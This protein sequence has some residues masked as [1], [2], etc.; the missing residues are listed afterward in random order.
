MKIA[1]ITSSYPQG[2][3]FRGGLE[4]LCTEIAVGMAARGHKIT[5]LTTSQ[6]P[7]AK[8]S[9][10]GGITVIRFR[11]IESFFSRLSLNLGLSLHR[12]KSEFDVILNMEY[13]NGFLSLE[14]A[15]LCSPKITVLFPL[16]HAMRGQDRARTLLHRGYRIIGALILE[17]SVGIVCLSRYEAESL[18]SVFPGQ[19]H[20]VTIIRP[21]VQA[22]PRAAKPRFA[23][24]ILVIS[25]LVPFKGVLSVIKAL[26]LLPNHFLDVVGDGPQRVELEKLATDMG[27]RPRIKF[28]GYV[29][30]AEKNELLGSASVLVHLS[31]VESYSL[32]VGEALASGLPCVVRNANAL[33]EW[34]DSRSCI[35]VEDPENS[36]SLALSIVRAESLVVAKRIPTTEEYAAI[37][38]RYLDRIVRQ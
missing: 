16:F 4:K 20:K 36:Q 12:H 2:T 14:A 22:A 7:S 32:V 29:S 11:W 35:G 27:I 37:L 38:E 3:V 13:W 30:D 25:S 15:V 24:K 9:C 23:F 1:I 21:G 10:A 26:T 19:R 8:T 6:G 5:V 34:I 28:H 33:R 18:L 17:R 31:S